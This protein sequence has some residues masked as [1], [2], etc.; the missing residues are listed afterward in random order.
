MVLRCEIRE[1]NYGGGRVR[2]GIVLEWD[3]SDEPCPASFKKEIPARPM[4]DVGRGRSRLP[5][6]TLLYRAAMW[7]VER[8]SRSSGQIR[9]LHSPHGF[10]S[11]IALQVSRWPPRM[12]GGRS[13]DPD[14]WIASDRTGREADHEAL[15]RS[16]ASLP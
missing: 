6:M 7:Q 12:S 3:R 16:P 10:F 2:A 8:P 14:R 1:V 5:E 11:S 15:R 13:S 9:I 4:R